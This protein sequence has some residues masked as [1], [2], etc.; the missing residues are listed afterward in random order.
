MR[1][2]V[3]TGEKSGRQVLVACDE[4]GHPID[5]VRSCE[6][7]QANYADVPRLRL[8]IV[9]FTLDAPVTNSP[10]PTTPR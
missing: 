7:V 4:D 8:E 1:I 9:D 5:G 10:R 6:I 2:R 3:V